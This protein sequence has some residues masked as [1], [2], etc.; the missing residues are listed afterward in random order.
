MRKR[1]ITIFGAT[2]LFAALTAAGC[3]EQQTPQQAPQQSA[4][5][6]PGQA[7]QAAQAKDPVAWGKFLV[8]FGGCHD[9][10]TPKVFTDHGIVLD[11]LRL[12]SGHP[13]NTVLPKVDPAMIQPGNW[14]LF[15]DQFTAAVGAWGVSFAA[16]LT[17]DQTG[18]GL[19]TEE[20]FIKALRSGKHMGDG[21]PI[22]PP[23][24]WE[25]FKNVSDDDLKAIFAY[26]RTVK[27]IQNIV[28]GPVSPE[29]LVAGKFK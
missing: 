14:V 2:L 6:V 8:D 7:I 25:N 18:L 24:P 11:S 28:H 4:K 19:W 15:S 12:L 26:L 17:P 3:S 20:M 29:D 22:L 16:N 21:R 9:C 5:L 13:Q 1:S 23:M 10:H 27:P